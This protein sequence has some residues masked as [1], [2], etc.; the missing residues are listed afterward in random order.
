MSTGVNAEKGFVALPNAANVQS[1]YILCNPTGDYGLSAS[2][3]PNED[4]RNTCAVSSEDLLKSPTY[5]PIDGFRL[6]G[7]MVSD[8]EIPKPEGGDRPDVAV[9]TDAIWRNKENTEC[10]LGAH[11]QMK[12]A[13]LANGKYLEVNDIA[14]A[15]FAGKK[16]SVAYFH[17][18]PHADIGGNAEVLF[19]AG[20]TFTSVKTTPLNTQLPSVKDA[21][22]ANTAISERNTAS[23]SE[24]WVDFTTDVSFKDADGVTRE[25]S[26]IFYTKYPCDAQDPV[27]KSGA[28]RLRTTGQSGLEPKEISVSGLVPVEGTVDKF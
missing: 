24:N 10:I 28:I 22:A 12:D 2:T 5:A 20:R 14:R 8:V 9:L 17:K 25:H 4:S 27:P 11:L 16:I 21:P 18:Q 1:A 19:R 26:S 15:G 13:P 23:F 3:V 7:I 6:V